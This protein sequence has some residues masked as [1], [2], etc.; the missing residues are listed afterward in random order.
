MNWPLAFILTIALETAVLFLF[1]RKDTAL[2][3]I[4]IAGVLANAVT[5]PFVWFLFPRFATSYGSYILMAEMFA[6]FLEVPIIY[7]I[8][9]PK[10]WYMSIAASAAANGVSYGVGMILYIYI[11]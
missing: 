11:L 9:R 1:F 5:H 10:P 4:F 6:F 7:L 8:I 2:S 3:R